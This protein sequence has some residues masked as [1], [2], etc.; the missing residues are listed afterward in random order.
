MFPTVPYIRTR[1]EEFNRLY[2]ENSLPMLPFCLSKARCFRGRLSYKRTLVS[3]NEYR[4]SDFVLRISTCFDL[5]EEEVEDIILHEMI[6]YYIAYHHLP[7]TSTHGHL[8]RRHMARINRMGNRHITISTRLTPEQQ[9]QITSVRK[10]HV[11]AVAHFR[12]GRLGIKVVPRQVKVIVHF[13]REALRCFPIDTIRWYY[14]E[15][16]YFNQYPSSHALRLYY[17]SDNEALQRA[18]TTA[19]PISILPDG[20]RLEANSSSSLSW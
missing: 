8:F 1:F 12:D 2:F 5:P 10:P 14:T 7:D 18:L 3:R 15:D 20:V 6:H 9:Q 17:V 16:G 4:N 13:N 19:R 11:V